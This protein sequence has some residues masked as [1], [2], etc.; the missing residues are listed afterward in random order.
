[1]L[2]SDKSDPSFALRSSVA[3]AATDAI[4]S[5]F[6]SALPRFMAVYYAFHVLCASDAIRKHGV[7]MFVF[8][9]EELLEEPER[10]NTL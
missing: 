5:D 10:V 2:P 9:Y 3:R 1:M 8:S 7:K 6:Y 4:N